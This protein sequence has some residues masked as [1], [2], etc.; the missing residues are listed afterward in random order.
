MSGALEADQMESLAEA[1]SNEHNRVKRLCLWENDIGNGGAE[2]LA[3]A[4]ESSN[5]AVLELVLDARR[6]I[7]TNPDASLFTSKINQHGAQALAQALVHKNNK[8]QELS[9]G[10]GQIGPEGAE[11]LAMALMSEHNKIQS[12]E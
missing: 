2:A 5:L 6:S 7:Q 9:L 8:L 1:L 10:F 12:L 4:L 3:E 11:A